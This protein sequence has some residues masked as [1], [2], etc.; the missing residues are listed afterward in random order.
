VPRKHFGYKRPEYTV[1]QNMRRRCYDPGYTEYQRYAGRGIEVCERWR[2][3]FEAFFADMGPR[4]GRGFSLERR[5]NS[6]H[7]EPGNCYWATAQEQANNRRNNTLVALGNRTQ[8]LAQ[9]CREI[10]IK[11]HTVMTRMGKRGW[12]VE[13]ALLTPVRS[14]SHDGPRAQRIRVVRLAHEW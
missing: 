14:W 7:Y 4:P 5:N 13:R 2:A 10:G 9:W 3:S 8:T 12:S 1:W 11:H 6:G